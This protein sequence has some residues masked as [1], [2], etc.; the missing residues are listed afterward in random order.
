MMKCLLFLFVSTLAWAETSNEGAKVNKN[1]NKAHDF[2]RLLVEG[3]LKRPE[4]SIVTGD[5][6]ENGS[7]LLSL[8][9]DFLDQEA[10]Q[11][12]VEIP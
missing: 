1:Q 2:S 12:G 5:G 10:A 4:M 3:Q 7:G 9:E 11:L 8:R 6:G